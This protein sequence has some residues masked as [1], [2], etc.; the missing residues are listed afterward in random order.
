[1]PPLEIEFERFEVIE[2]HSATIPEQEEESSRIY[3]EIEVPRDIRLQTIQLIPPL[4]I[5]F[6]R[7]EEIIWKV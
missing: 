7:F 5:E 4:E 6:E 3:V 2:L 1:M